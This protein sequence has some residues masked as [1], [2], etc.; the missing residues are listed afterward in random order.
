[1]C[2]FVFAPHEYLLEYTW[3]AAARCA[4]MLL[5]L[6]ALIVKTICVFRT[7]LHITQKL[8]RNN[9]TNDYKPM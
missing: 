4:V 1:M 9:S 7:Q 8:T 3:Y 6:F 2:D 5:V